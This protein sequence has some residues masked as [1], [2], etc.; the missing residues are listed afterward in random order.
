MSSNQLAGMETETAMASKEGAAAV[1]AA[2]TSE[3]KTFEQKVEEM[4][5]SILSKE[6][7][8][9]VTNDENCHTPLDHAAVHAACLK[10]LGEK[11]RETQ[12]VY[13][14]PFFNND[15]QAAVVYVN[16]KPVLSADDSL[17]CW[18]ATKAIMNRVEIAE[19]VACTLGIMMTAIGFEVF[20]K[21]SAEPF[22]AI[23]KGRE[24]M[25]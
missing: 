24:D 4:K 11:L 25:K 8:A 5:N 17:C 10:V 22:T 12:T 1:K 2:A 9:L 23:L 18:R 15:I 3:S 14:Y 19:S 16:N 7:M 21:D 20:L 6:K 13:I